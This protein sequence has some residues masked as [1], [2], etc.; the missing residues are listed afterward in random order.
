[1]IQKASDIRVKHIAHLLPQERKR[2]CIQRL[3]LAAAWSK[4]I[5]ESPKI[6]L[7]NLVED[8]DHGLL[9]DLVFQRRDP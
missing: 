1:M 9:N 4:P 3:V 5:R 7:I 8:G 2:Q 6:L